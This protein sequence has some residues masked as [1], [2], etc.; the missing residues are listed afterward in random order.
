MNNWKYKFFLQTGTEYASLGRDGV[1]LQS[2]EHLDRDTGPNE[3][4]TLGPGPELRVHVTCTVNRGRSI[5][6]VGMT[7][8]ITVLDEDDNPPVAQTNRHFL[9]GSQLKEVS[10]NCLEGNVNSMSFCPFLFIILF[11]LMLYHLLTYY[12]IASSYISW[13]PQSSS[14]LRNYSKCGVYTVESEAGC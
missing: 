10:K 3:G 12:I 2:R 13:N 14:T 4:G 1:S 9:N 5:S 7:V 11:T 8:R 6:E